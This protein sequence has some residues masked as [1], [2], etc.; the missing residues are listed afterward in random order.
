MAWACALA[1]G[2]C[3]SDGFVWN[4]YGGVW[5][6]ARLPVLSILAG[7]IQ[8]SGDEDLGV[9][10]LSSLELLI[11]CEL[12]AGERLMLARQFRCI[13][14]GSVHFRCRVFHFAEAS[15][16]GSHVVICVL[17]FELCGICRVV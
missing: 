10:G 2:E 13:F 15:I 4:A 1:S 5:D 8:H 7:L 6:R 16:F 12:S 9:G 17:C 3:C 14:V 11:L